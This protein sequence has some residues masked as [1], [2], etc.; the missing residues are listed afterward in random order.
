MYLEERESVEWVNYWW[1]KANITK[2]KRWILLGDSV[3]RQFRRKIQENVPDKA[4]DFWGV[5]LQLDDKR[6]KKELENFFNSEYKYELAIITWGGHHGLNRT[7]EEENKYLEWYKKYE[8]LLLIVK[9]KCKDVVIVAATHEVLQENLQTY[10]EKRNSEIKRRN[11][12]SEELAVKYNLKYIDLF[13][14]MYEQRY[15]YPHID[16]VHFTRDADEIMAR[17]IIDGIN[18]GIETRAYVNY[19]QSVNSIRELENIINDSKEIVL[20]GAGNIGK[21][22]AQYINSR[23][24]KILCFI[25]SDNETIAKH[26]SLGYKVYHFSEMEHRFNDCNII[27]TMMIDHVR[28]IMNKKAIYYWKP[29]SKVI[30]FVKEYNSLL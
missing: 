6:F 1:E 25:V 7:I 22:F 11:K 23:G 19:R 8:E 20:Y 26:Y 17:F 29:E 28:E 3:A 27:V 13:N 9:A 16:H 10:D 30:D 2:I 12:V 15:I 4:V 18:S 14:Y 24:K 5:S 21:E